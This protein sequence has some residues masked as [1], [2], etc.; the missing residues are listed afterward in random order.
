VHNFCVVDLGGF[1][2]DLLKDRLYT[3]PKKSHARS[4]EQTALFHVAEA[5]VRWLAPILSFTADEIWGFMPGK[6]GE[7]VFLET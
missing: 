1:Y 7:S 5:M 2:V 3:T 6:R 4:S